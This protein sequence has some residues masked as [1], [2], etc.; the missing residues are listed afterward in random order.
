MYNRSKVSMSYSR[1]ILGKY[2]KGHTLF[3]TMQ[4]NF[5]KKKRLGLFR[6][7]IVIIISLLVPK[8]QMNSFQ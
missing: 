5:Q 3:K 1:N 6:Y 2:V 4:F 8:D 7:R